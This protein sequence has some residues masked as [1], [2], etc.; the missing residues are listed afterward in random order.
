MLYRCD[1]ASAPAEAALLVA[2]QISGATVVELD[3][4]DH[5]PFLGDV[6][7][8]VAEIAHFV[9]GERR[10]PPPKRLLAALMFTDLVA[11]TERAASV[12]DAR[13]KSVLDR[14]DTALRAVVGSCGGTVIKTTGDGI[15]AILPC[16]GDALRAAE[17]VRETLKLDGLDV[18]IGI[19][20]GDIDRRGEDVSGL[21]VVVAARAMALAG[22]NQIVVGTVA[23]SRAIRREAS[24]GPRIA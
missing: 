18:R 2:D 7:A 11:S 6:D 22:A 16:A 3:G 14:H 10:L 1:D 9:V 8:V 23:L 21:G 12:G 15:L 17:R 20:V 24:G 13:W 4:G 19:H 5:F